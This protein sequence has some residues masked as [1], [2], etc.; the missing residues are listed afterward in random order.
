LLELMTP[1]AKDAPADELDAMRRL[2]NE[3]CRDDR[4]SADAQDCMLA[5]TSL[6]DVG[7]RCGDKLTPEQMAA[8]GSAIESR[9]GEPAPPVDAGT[10][11]R[12]GA[13]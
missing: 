9:H 8:F 11:D 4:W 1:A 13:P 10:A 5:A 7:G 6:Q 12:D 2:F 3:H